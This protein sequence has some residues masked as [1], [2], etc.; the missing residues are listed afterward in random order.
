MWEQNHS[1]LNIIISSCMHKLHTFAPLTKPYTKMNKII[2]FLFLSTLSL[3]SMAQTPAIQRQNN[4]Y[5][6]GEAIVCVNG[7]NRYTRALYSHN[8]SF[9]VETSD[10]PI[11]AI[12][13][14]KKEC[15][16]LSLTMKTKNTTLRMDSV[17]YCK[18]RYE[19]G[20]R[21]YLLRDEHWNEG[22][23][24]ISVLADKAQEGGIWKIET[25][26]FKEKVTF[27]ASLCKSVSQKPNRN[28]DIGSFYKSGT[29]E[30]SADRA[31]LRMATITLNNSIGYITI[32]GGDF[33][34]LK[35]GISKDFHQR[36]LQAEQDNKTLAS[37][38]KITTPD[39]YLNTLGS[40]IVMTADGAWDGETWEHGAIGWRMPLPGWRAAYMGDFLGMS[41]RQRLHFDAYAESMVTSE[42]VRLP[43]EQDSS[44]NLARGVYKWGTPMYSNGYICRNPHKN[45]QFHHYD[46]NLVYIDELLWHFQFDADTAYMRRMWP[47]LKSHLAWEKNTWDPDNDGLYDAYCC[48]WASDALQYNSGAVTHS[49]AYNYR[50]NLLT[51]RIAT[52]L[53]EN[54]QPYQT[55][56]DK[57][58]KAM[59]SRL[60][61]PEKGVW[62]EFQ[63]FMGLKRL[64][65][66]PAL[67]TIYTTID[68][69]S[70][71]KEQAYQAMKW[72]DQEIPHIPYIYNGK[73]YETLSTSNWAPYEWSIN[74]VAMAEVMHTALAYYEAGRPDEATKLLKANVIDFMYAG[75]SP[76]NFGQLSALD[77]NTGEGYRDFA[78][79]TGI[80][81]RAI[82]QGLFGIT[83]QALDGKCFIRP[84]FPQEWNDASI[85]TPYIDYTFQ[86][87]NGK[88]VYEIR[89][90]FKQPLQ[91]VLQ[92]N[93][94]KGEVKEY[95]ASNDSII[96]MEV[97][98]YRYEIPVIEKKDVVESNPSTECANVNVAVCHTLNLSKM[99]NANVTDIFKNE[100]LSPRSPYTTLS[101]PKQGIGDWC[102][103]KRT[104]EI[105]DAALRSAGE[106]MT[107]ANIPFA[108]PSEGKNIIYTSL[109]DNY[110]DSVSIPLKGKATRIFLLMAG[111]TNPMQ[112]QFDNGE[113]IVTYLD[114]GKETL[115]LRNPDNWCPIEQDYD[116][117]PWAFRLKKDRPLRLALKT[118]QVSRTL[119]LDMHLSNVGTSSDEPGSKKPALT[120]PGGAAQLLT[121]HTNPQ[122]KLK[123]LTLK[124]TANDVVIGLLGVTIEKAE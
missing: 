17:K 76:G 79:V 31:N 38:I 64:H 97:P 66:A 83:P 22:E 54:P 104:A 122:K 68:S 5:P 7:N 115:I 53:G 33:A 103:T 14:N 50:A 78:D 16:N 113:V 80:S 77:R 34:I 72:V 120:I 75:V 61:M 20:C 1:C 124:T 37:L 102:S 25:K 106:R 3:Y 8:S 117:D 57:I 92:Q 108:T 12:Y 52:L 13:Q 9:R 89:P 44:N 36:Y 41:T 112:S 24:H 73:T 105:N 59:N 46:M 11:F 90:R 6:E 28:G 45:H 87:K 121:I 101:L 43:H 49:S 10:R 95:V 29:F 48:I 65:D 98:T 91:I 84:G 74:N 82:I 63:D 32:D 18:A 100:Y 107:V 27:E 42:P 71:S 94:G 123:A 4:Y 35:A 39:A 23:I 67:W 15:C 55:E 85:H 30:A 99:M 56:A 21:S 40:N 93:I 60:W 47:V 62:A 116:D 26:G 114:G 118:G 111:S 88:D 2:S 58:L 51:A 81:S 96:V 69:K 110:P 119:A 19:A 109:W 86:R 70:C